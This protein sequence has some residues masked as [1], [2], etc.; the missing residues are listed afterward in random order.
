MGKETGPLCGPCWPS[1]RAMGQ[2]D[3]RKEPWVMLSTPKE[4]RVFSE[5]ILMMKNATDF[6][7]GA[8]FQVVSS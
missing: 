6:C 1:Q 2:V 3:Y 5:V 7:M 8:M 4:Q